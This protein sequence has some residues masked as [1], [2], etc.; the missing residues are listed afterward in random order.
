MV[1]LARES[2]WGRCQCCG[3]NLAD[4][5]AVRVAYKQGRTWVHVACGKLL[6]MNEVQFRPGTAAELATSPLLG[7]CTCAGCGEAI[8]PERC[9]PQ[10]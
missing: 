4:E 5:A 6:P 10:V 9:I 7:E 1:R 8:F 3:A 2:R